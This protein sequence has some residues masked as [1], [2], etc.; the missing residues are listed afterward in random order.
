MLRSVER[1]AKRERNHK[2]HEEHKDW[3]SHPCVCSRL[4][5]NGLDTWNTDACPHRQALEEGRHV[6]LSEKNSTYE[7]REEHEEECLAS[8]SSMGVQS[9][10]SIRSGD[11]PKCS[12][13]KSS[14]QPRVVSESWSLIA[15]T[16]LPES[17]I[18][19]RKFGAPSSNWSPWQ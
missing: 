16:A 4:L 1:Y 6:P 19:D 13:T 14:I 7:G 18:G 5:L 12:P 9:G 17:I 3:H 11:I 10:A 2:G 15:S 8:Y